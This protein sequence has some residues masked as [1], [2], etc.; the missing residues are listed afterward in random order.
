MVERVA[1]DNVVRVPLL[2]AAGHAGGRRWPTRCPTAVK[3]ERNARAPRGDHARR[4]GAQPRARGPRRGARRRRR[5]GRTRARLAGR[6]RCNRVVNFDGRGPRARRR[7]SCR[8]ASPRSC[9]TACAAHARRATRP[10]GRVGGTRHVGRDEGQAAGAGPAVE[11]ARCIILRDD[12][13]KRSLPIWVGLPEANAIALELEKIPTPR[14]MTHDLIK[15]ILETIEAR[16][17][18]VVVTDLK[19]NTFFAMIHLQLG[20]AEIT[21][22]SRPVRRDRARPARGGA[23]LRR[24]GGACAKAKSV[25]VAGRRKPRSRRR[26]RTRPKVKEWLQNRSSRGTSTKSRQGPDGTARSSRRC[27]SRS[28]PTTTCRSAAGSPPRSRRCGAGS[29]PA[30]TTRG[31]SRRASAAPVAEP[32]RRRPLPV[33]ARRRPIRSSRSGPVVARSRRGACDARASTCSTRTIR[34]CSA[35]PR[36]GWRGALGAPLVFTYHTRYEKYAHYVPLPRAA[37]G[38]GRGRGSHAASPPRAD[39]VVAPSAQIATS[40]PRAACARPIAVVP[41]GVDLDALPPGRPR[42]RRGA[43]LGL[44]ADDR[45]LPLRGTARSREERGARASTRSSASRARVPRRAARA[46]RAGDPRPTRSRAARAASPAGRPHP[47]SRAGR[48]RG[49][50]RRA[51]RPPTCSCSRRRPRRRASCSPRPPRAGCPRWPCAVR[52]AT[53]SCATARRACSP[54][55]T[56]GDAGRSGHRPPARR[57]AARARWRAAAR[58]SPSGS[59]TSRAADRAHARTCTRRLAARAG[60]ARDGRRPLRAI[61]GSVLQREWDR[62]RGRQGACLFRRISGCGRC[63]GCS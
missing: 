18:K 38:R 21:V 63:A 6:T 46:R 60:R 44:P 9:R 41:T 32:P 24:R 58:A 15:S 1:Y 53:R 28:S 26:P 16:V 36:G 25:E 33:A 40:S 47:L 22:D 48:P 57:R 31:S 43:A 51:T 50:R 11:P 56:R 4:G 13:E 10:I 45:A 29:R 12:E 37:R 30:A 23:D 62:R 61:S 14:P 20:G 7:P 5:R 54:S 52:G 34:S 39:R 42:A 49:A 2:A 35:P 3:A 8:C 27:G 59:S 17:L 55:P 19:E